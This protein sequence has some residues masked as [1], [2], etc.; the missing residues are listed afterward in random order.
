MK[1]CSKLLIFG[2]ELWDFKIRLSRN[3]LDF[4]YRQSVLFSKENWIWWTFHFLFL[5]YFFVFSREILETI[6]GFGNNFNFT[7]GETLWNNKKRNENKFSRLKPYFSLDTSWLYLW[8][9][10]GGDGNRPKVKIVPDGVLEV[11]VHSALR[12]SG[13]QVLTKITGDGTWKYITFRRM[14]I[15]MFFIFCW[16]FVLIFSSPPP[17]RN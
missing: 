10:P 15:R 13:V 7:W 3:N 4:N 9:W 8:N 11:V 16:K 5:L 17:R 2:T 1:Y 12:E 14:K 6:F